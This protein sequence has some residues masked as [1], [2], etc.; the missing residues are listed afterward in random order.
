[1]ASSGAL[2]AAGR[3]W[4]TGT[5]AA[6]P[7]LPAQELA[8]TGAEA[9]T[10][11]RGLA[12][13]GLAGTV[14]VIAARGWLRPLVGL[15]LLLAGVGIIAA[16]LGFDPDPSLAAASP[17]APGRTIVEDG[18]T[19]WP[20]LS[21]SCGA[22]LALAGVLVVVRGR[23]G[24]GLSQK[25]DSPVAGTRPGPGPAAPAA[26][27]AA[28]DPAAQDT[29]AQERATHDPAVQDPAAQERALWERGLWEALDRG[30]DP[31]GKGPT[32]PDPTSA[33]GPPPTDEVDRPPG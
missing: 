18:T 31:T 23:G 32:A 15:L 28:Q 27:A 6:I 2:V 26:G 11:V 13:V 19:L 9:G 22:G 12:V 7:P 25:Y 30:E 4:A 21:A 1:M 8:V 10:P 24:G 14:A 16:S 5:V 33:P 20:V 3:T 29:D 17:V